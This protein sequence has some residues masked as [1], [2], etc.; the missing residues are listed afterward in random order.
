M[1]EVWRFFVLYWVF[2]LRIMQLQIEVVI[3]GYILLVGY[4]G[5][6]LHFIF[7]RESRFYGSGVPVKV[8]DAEVWELALLLIN[9][10]DITILWNMSLH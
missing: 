4:R 8:W 7:L 3:S 6:I 1:V 9:G 2:L 5:R 10:I